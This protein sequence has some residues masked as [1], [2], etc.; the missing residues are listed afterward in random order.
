[1]KRILQWLYRWWNRCPCCLDGVTEPMTQDDFDRIESTPGWI[2]TSGR[3]CD[4]CTWVEFSAFKSM[5]PD[6][7]SVTE[8]DT[9]P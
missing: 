6:S 3:Q 8:E 1:M 2:L 5:W 7:E 4:T 9:H